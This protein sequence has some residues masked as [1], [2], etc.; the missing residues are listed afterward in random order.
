MRTNLQTEQ[1]ILSVYNFLLLCN[2]GEP[3]SRSESTVELGGE[4]PDVESWPR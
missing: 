3:D 1:T 4:Q 2:F